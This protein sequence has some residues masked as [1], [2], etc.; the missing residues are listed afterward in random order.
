MIPETVGQA[1][2]A[3]LNDIHFQQQQEKDNGQRIDSSVSGAGDGTN[4]ID[5]ENK[6]T[7]TTGNAEFSV[8]MAMLHRSDEKVIEGSSKD[9]V[10]AI[11]VELPT[12]EGGT[13]VT[14]AL[15][16]SCCNGNLGG[17]IS[18]PMLQE[19]IDAGVQVERVT[20][21]SVLVRTANGTVRTDAWINIVFTIRHHA[22]SFELPLKMLVLNGLQRKEL[23]FSFKTMYD[24]GISVNMK[25]RQME[26]YGPHEI[27][28]WFPIPT[29]EEVRVKERK[30]ATDIL[31]RLEDSAA[32]CLRLEVATT[33]EDLGD[34]SKEALFD[35]SPSAW[36]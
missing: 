8:Q 3:N 22:G 34:M 21:S 19:M 12:A 24:Y 23:L 6:S 25:K 10:L 29:M 35:Y 31:R 9:R 13:F 36:C 5:Y 27:A 18:E 14:H 20:G 1:R 17:A 28:E 7:E 16:D 32:A 4:I 2:D 33:P 26:V 11:E 30:Q 15:C